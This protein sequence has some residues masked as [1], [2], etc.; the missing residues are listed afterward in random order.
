MRKEKK[1]KKL[2]GFSLFELLVTMGI[3]MILST[4]VFPL[5]TQKAQLAKLEGYASQLVTDI[6][7]QQQESSLKNEPRGIAIHNNGYTIFDGETL[8]TSTDQ[9]FKKYPSNISIWA[10]SLSLGN[11]I[12]FE[13]GK[14]KP[15]SYGTLIVS[16]GFYSVQVYINNEGLIGYETL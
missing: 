9:H 6:Y 3:L 13:S 8:S 5:A 1:S 7:F 11:E 16:D 14:F 4:I 12:L 10:I 2:E 15:T